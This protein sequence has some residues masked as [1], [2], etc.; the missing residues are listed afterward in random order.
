FGAVYLLW[1]FPLGFP[2]SALPTALPYGAL[3]FL[4]GLRISCYAQKIGFGGAITR[5]AF[6]EQKY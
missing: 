3:T 6:K 2:K 4:P 1:H 5:L